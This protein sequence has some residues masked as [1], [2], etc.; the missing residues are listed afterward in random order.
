MHNIKVTNNFE[1]FPESIK[2]PHTIN[3]SGVMI[4]TSWGCCCKFISGQIKLPGQIWTLS[5][6]PMENWKSH[7]NKGPREFYILSNEG[8]NSEF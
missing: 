3:S 7:K 2:H 6:L 4:T 1:A 5:L 8:E